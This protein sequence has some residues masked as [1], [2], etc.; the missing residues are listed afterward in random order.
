MIEPGYSCRKLKG[1]EL[2]AHDSVIDA[3]SNVLTQFGTLYAWAGSAQQPR[4]LRGRAPVFVARVPGAADATIVVRHAWHGGMLAPITRDLYFRPTRAPDE[5]RMS[6]SL[7]ET[8]IATPEFMA[9]ALYDAGLGVVRVDVATRF[10]E[11]SND[12]AAVLADHVPNITRAE[13]FAAVRELLAQMS[14]HGFVHPDLNVKN[15]LLYRVAESVKAA[16]LDVDV[17]Q[18][19]PKSEGERAA[20]DNFLRLDRSLQKAERQFGIKLSNEEYETFRALM[21]RGLPHASVSRRVS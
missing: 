4:A 2:V 12:F 11:N 19:I 10:V 7:R 16:V 1:V 18:Q 14:T 13:A 6:R 8:G 9:Y 20:M 21:M 17:M 3:L 5:L 15:I